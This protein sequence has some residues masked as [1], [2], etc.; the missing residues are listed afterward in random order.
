MQADGADLGSA[1]A[2]EHPAGDLPADGAKSKRGRKPKFTSEELLQRMIAV[3]V[4]TVLASGV[5]GGIESVRIDK[6][7]AQAD[8]PRA[9]AYALFDRLS[10]G[11]PQHNLR[12]A[13]VAHIVRT[14]PAGNVGATRDVA[15][16]ALADLGSAPTD[17]ETLRRTQ[18]ETLRAV[19][20][21]NYQSLQ[22]QR[23]KVYRSLAASILTTSDVELHQAV[24]EGEERLVSAYEGLL[25]EL[26][27]VFGL[28]P[29][30]PF[31][32]R[33][34]AM[35]TIALNEGLSNKAAGEYDQQVVEIDGQEWTLFAVGLEALINAFV[36]E[37]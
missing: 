12:R 33:E 25:E 7:I 3:A 20:N 14:F 13:V 18:R 6:V 21:Y 1:K 36:V 19:A 9:A 35:S 28:A 32:L 10:D 15:M 27:V 17:T 31:T 8:V 24:A 5:S 29:R 4:D 37:I 2:S 34:L 16:S 30:S 23:W 11:A 26:A 22:S